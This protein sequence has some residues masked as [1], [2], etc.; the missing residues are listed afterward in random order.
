MREIVNCVMLL[1]LNIILLSLNNYMGH[2]I[3]RREYI[4]LLSLNNYMG[5]AN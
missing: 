3:G 4:I 5:H 2:A 1:S